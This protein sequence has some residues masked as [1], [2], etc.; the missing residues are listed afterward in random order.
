MKKGVTNNYAF[1]YEVGAA[2][3]SR[4][5]YVSRVSIINRG[6]VITASDPYGYN[7]ADNPGVTEIGAGGFLADGSVLD[8]STVSPS[9]LLNE[10]TVFPVKNGVLR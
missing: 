2:I 1:S 10:V 3:T 5:P 7:T 6:Q 8:A 9:M 4:G